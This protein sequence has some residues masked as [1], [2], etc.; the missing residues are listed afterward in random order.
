MRGD[1]FSKL[2]DVCCD[3]AYYDPPYG[4]NNEKMPPSRVRYKS[5]YHLWAS[6]IRN[7]R[8][9]LF[10]KALRRKDTSDK[11]A[12]S[13]FEEFRKSDSGKFIAVEAIEQVI[14]KNSLRMDYLVI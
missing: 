11:V 3:L 2:D 6:I 13:V 1:I 8:P 4:S 5:Y 14:K 10:G 7:D 12:N 9:K